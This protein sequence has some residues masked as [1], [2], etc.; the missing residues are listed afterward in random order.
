MERMPLVS[1][2]LKS[3]GYDDRTHV[4]EVEFVHG[5]AYR[6][7]DVPRSVYEGLLAADSRGAYFDENVRKAGYRVEKIT[8]AVPPPKQPDAMTNA[9]NAL[10]PDGVDG[11]DGSA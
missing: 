2:A 10:P 5:S 3:A 1:A 6:Y 8:G 7:F 4:L 9:A 11:L